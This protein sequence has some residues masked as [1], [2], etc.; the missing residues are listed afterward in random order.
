MKVEYV[1]ASSEGSSMEKQTETIP[2]ELY[3]SNYTYQTNLYRTEI[4]AHS[5]QLG[6]VNQCSISQI[7]LRNVEMFF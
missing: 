4:I 5:D 6:K 2:I 3:L 7:L 1:T